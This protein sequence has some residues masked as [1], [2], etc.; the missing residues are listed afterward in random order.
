[1][2]LSDEIKMKTP[3]SL[4]GYMGSMTNDDIRKAIRKNGAYKR[5]D[6]TKNVYTVNCSVCGKEILSNDSDEAMTETQASV[7]KR[8][9]AVFWHAKCHKKFWKTKIH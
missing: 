9:T 5:K 7:T 3:A 1:M 8:S 2:T 4:G 6:G